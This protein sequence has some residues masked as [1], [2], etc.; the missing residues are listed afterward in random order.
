MDLHTLPDRWNDKIQIN[1]PVFVLDKSHPSFIFIQFRVLNILQ[2]LIVGSKLKLCRYW[3][4]NIKQ[5]AYE[6]SS[7]FVFGAII[8]QSSSIIINLDADAAAAADFHLFPPL[9]FFINLLS[10][11]TVTSTFVVVLI[12][13][14]IYHQFALLYSISVNS[15]SN[16]CSSAAIETVA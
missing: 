2:L 12:I 4:Y 5:K 7:Y 14:I 16:G 6:E 10:V 1:A 13:P 15:S 8:A 11:I 3:R 9:P